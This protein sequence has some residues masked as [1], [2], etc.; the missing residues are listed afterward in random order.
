[1][2][3]RVQSPGGESHLQHALLGASVDQRDLQRGRER[4]RRDDAGRHV[5]V[6]GLRLCARSR[7]HKAGLHQR[8]SAAAAQRRREEGADALRNL[9]ERLSRRA[10]GQRLV[11]ARAALGV[12]RDEGVVGGA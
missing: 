6:E 9:A 2:A 3:S 11:A 4:R 1:M 12:A 5:A 8:E 10:H 7:H